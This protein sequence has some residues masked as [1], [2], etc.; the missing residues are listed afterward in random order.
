MAALLRSLP[1]AIATAV[2]VAVPAFA[3]PRPTD[4]PLTPAAVAL[5][6][7][8]ANQPEAQQLLSAA[9]ASPR[10]DVRYI[11]ARVARTTNSAA[12]IAALEQALANEAPGPARREM[13][14]ALE[15]LRGARPVA[16]APAGDVA[17]ASPA[18]AAPAAS[19]PAPAT[20]VVRLWPWPSA[21]LAQDLLRA[22]GC[23]LS[24]EAPFLVAH[25]DFRQNGVIQRGAIEAERL[26]EGCQRLARALTT[27]TLASSGRPI[28]AG[29]RDI[30]VMPFD[31]AFLACLAESD[32]APE[33]TPRR[34]APRPEEPLRVSGT[35]TAPRKVKN[36]NPV[37]PLAAQ[38]RLAQGVVVLEATITQRGC[39]NEVGVVRSVDPQLDFAA[40]RAVMQW[41]YTPTLLEG[42]PVPVIMTVTVNF[43]LQP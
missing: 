7:E 28:Q 14:H 11:A 12:Q 22:T 38:K 30:V 25:I 41:R 43:S 6:V 23:K 36:V 3:Q 4:P 33:P 1:V 8:R 26:S 2:T 13:R 10:E 18:P 19:P 32:G 27:L 21:A 17:A 9:L 42:V 15:S 40:L 34:E 16:E 20:A 35:I 39:I 31:Q 29:V 37:Y 5:I 24:K